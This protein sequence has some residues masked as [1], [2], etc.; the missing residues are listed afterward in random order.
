MAEPA[1]N[2]P[3]QLTAEVHNS[4][5]AI[6]QDVTAGPLA[7]QAHRG[8]LSALH[9]TAC[10]L[11][12][13]QAEPAS[14]YL[15]DDLRNFL[16][17]HRPCGI[18]LLPPLSGNPKLAAL[19]RELGCKPICLAPD[20]LDAQQYFCSNDRLAAAD[21]T[22]YQVALGHRRIGFISGPEHCRAA[23]E[24]ELGYLDAMA[25]HGLDRDAAL[26]APGDGSL[27][28]GIA[29]A[30]LLL[31]VSPRPTAIFAASDEMAA[32]VLQAAHAMGIGVPGDLSVTG[33]GDSGAAALLCPPLTSVALPI[34]DM[35]FAAAIQ[36]IGRE[37]APPQPVEFFGTLVAR[38]STGPVARA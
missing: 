23:R 25:S 7:A 15:L 27:A 12:L 26:I 32:G 4:T 17:R 33:F 6:V 16:E 3:A 31:E 13:F 24:R 18:I 14:P 20:A 37:N 2:R 10:A 35:A 19:C 34:G 11:S 30:R 28:S 1:H 36:L 38:G 21:A 22:N 5:I 29:A 9:D 8:A